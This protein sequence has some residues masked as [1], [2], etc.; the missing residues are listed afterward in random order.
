LTLKSDSAESS[1]HR[2]A[3]QKRESQE[4]QNKKEFP[5]RDGDTIGKARPLKLY[6]QGSK[7]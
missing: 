2:R 3:E 1:A 5:S 4:L 6:G 7:K